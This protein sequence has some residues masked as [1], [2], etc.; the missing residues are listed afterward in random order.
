[1]PQPDALLLIDPTCGGQAQITE[2]DFLKGAPELVAEISASSASIDLHEKFA[3]YRR[4][5]VR[6]Y[7]VWR[8]LD[9]EIDWFV[10]RG[11]QYR[12]LKANADGLLRSKVFPGLWLD[13][14][15]LLAGNLARVLAVVQQGTAS[16]EH[17]AF[18][19]RLRAASAGS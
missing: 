14:E 18:V 4:A 1:M 8:V 12:R 13:A 11:R 3:M 5:G 15:A 2:D 6:D 7:L 16:P 10:L 19:A 9:R 17:A